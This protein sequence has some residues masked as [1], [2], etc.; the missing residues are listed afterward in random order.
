MSRASALAEWRR[1]QA[2]LGAAVS[3][4]RDGYY[5]DAI[6]RAYYAVLHAAKAALESVNLAAPN[7]HEGVSNQFGLHIG[8]TGLVERHWGAEIRRLYALRNRAD[9]EVGAEFSDVDAQEVTE[10]AMAFLDRIG[11]LVASV[12]SDENV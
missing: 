10:R 9:Y 11:N 8:I 5:A 3:C 12:I 2:S 7:S 6:S 1:A 4:R